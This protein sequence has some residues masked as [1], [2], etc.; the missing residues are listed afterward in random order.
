MIMN[1]DAAKSAG[2]GLMKEAVYYD[3]HSHYQQA[4]VALGLPLLER[5]C[6]LIPKPRFENDIMIVDYGSASGG[7]SLL[8]M[9]SAIR[10]I[11]RRIS[12][13]VPIIILHNDQA[14]SDF[15]ALFKL[16]YETEESY[17]QN[18]LNVFTY[19]IG[20]SFYHHLTPSGRVYLGW[21][22]SSAHWLSRVPGA[23][24]G[25][26]WYRR[27]MA[28]QAPYFAEQARSDWL[29]F[30]ERRARELVPGGHLVA[31]LVGEDADGNCGGDRLLDFTNEVLQRMVDAHVL[32][33]A[34]YERMV[35]PV[36]F[37]TLDELK[38]PFA[39]YPLAGTVALDHCEQVT[40][41]NLLWTQYQNSGDAE[42]FA[43][44]SISWFRAIT[45]FTLFGALN[46][47]RT[48]DQRQG[49]IE[50]FYSELRRGVVAEP[51]TA[52]CHWRTA[53][54]LIRRI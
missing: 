42:S 15:S 1:K 50:D 37:R 48:V 18:N 14:G 41:P 22:S 38:E 27:R 28:S 7:N 30:I 45:E 17:L 33:A 4:V 9:Q 44:A 35:F 40:P 25:H 11:R 16:V 10:G 39:S 43:D 46:A 6:D 8:L 53:A 21:T 26:F 5:A 31:M 3:R 36:Y 19:A 51:A 29:T 20:R 23:L 54:L 47:D 32:R 13:Q 2:Q 34:E 24:S 49:L 52:Y 12:E